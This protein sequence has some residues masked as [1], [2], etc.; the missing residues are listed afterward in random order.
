MSISNLSDAGRDIGRANR[1][2]GVPIVPLVIFTAALCVAGPLALPIGKTPVTLSV[3]VL[4]AAGYLLGPFWG[5][6]PVAAYILAGAAGAPVF[7]GHAGGPS[8]LF[9]PTGGYIFGW[10]LIV[11]PAGL[12]ANRFRNPFAQFSGV[13]AGEL[14]FYIF[15]I[16][17]Y[18]AVSKSILVIAILFGVLSF[19]VGNLIQGV[20]G[21]L[22]GFLLRKLPPYARTEKG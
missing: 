2:K 6:V 13:I 17:W 14:A 8:I 18:M 11:F 19:L 4:V 16:V 21:F 5:L 12:F 20:A 7:S 9:G 15:G 22:V 3:F 10:L 1:P